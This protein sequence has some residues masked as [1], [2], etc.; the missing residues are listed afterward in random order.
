[1][2]DPLSFAQ[3]RLWF[4][5]QLDGPNSG[6]NNP[7]V[8]KL[9]GPLDQAA[10]GAALRDVLSRHESLRTMF[11][12]V[13]GEPYQRVLAVDELTWDLRVSVPADVAA[14]VREAVA[15]TFDLAAEIPIRAWLFEVGPEDHVLVLVVH[16]I[17]SDGWSMAP[18]G[19][20][21]A[22]AYAA[23]RAGQEPDW[24]ELPVQYRDYARWQHKLLGDDSDPD[25][26]LS[27]QVGYWRHAL[28]GA[29]EELTLPADRPRP[30]T[31]SYEGVRA[32]LDVPAHV[33][34]LVRDVARAARATPFMVLQAAFAVLLRRLG[35]GTDIPIGASV[36]GRTDDDLR[37]LVGFFVNTLVIR[38]DLAGD[39][40][41]RD[42][43]ARVRATALAAL[44]N[45]DVPFEKL[46]GDLAP[47]RS[48]SRH[49]LFQVMLTV[50][51][52]ARGTLELPDVQVDAMTAGLAAAKFDLDVNLGEVFDE[53]GAPAG[54][55]GVLIAAADLFDQETV[56]RIARQF[57]RVLETAV[58]D[59]TMR[60]DDVDVLDDDERRRILIEWNDA[61]HAVR[62]RSV[63]ESVAAVG[64]D[65]RLYVLDE[66]LRPVPP[67][68]VGELYLA[69]A[70]LGPGLPAERFVAC[71]F[72]GRMYRSG[73][74]ARWT[75]DGSV[76]LADD[77]VE[78]RGE[79]DHPVSATSTRGRT[80]VREELLRGVFAE[81]LG[82]ET[83]GVDDSFFDLG[84]YSLSAVR[85][86]SRI[87][88]VLGLEVRLRTLFDAPSVAQ[89][90]TRLEDEDQA[91]AALVPWQRP[92]RIPLSFA[93]RRLWFLAQI[94]G[95]NSTYNVP[96]VLRL[97]GELDRAALAQAL[98]DVLIRHESLR[99]I[100]AAAD[101]EPCQRIVDIDDLDW[102]PAVVDSPPDL[103]AAAA[104]CANHAF[105]LAAELP[106][107][108]WLFVVGPAEHVLV[109]VV[110]HIAT[111]G[112]S[113][114][115]LT[116]DIATAYTARAGGAEP[117]WRPLPVQYADYALWQRNLLGDESDPDSL[118]AKQVAYW[119]E[120]LSGTPAELT[121]PTDH[122]RP[123]T[124][125]HR[126]IAVPLE[127]APDLHR[128]LLAVA[129]ARGVTVFMLL[130]ASLAILLSRLGAG[131]DIPIG[132]GVAGRTDEALDD[133]VG[134][135]VNTLVVRTD[136]TGDPT[137]VDVLARVRETSLAGL[138]NQ[139][140]PFE[141][142]VEELAPT[143]SL[144]RNPLFQ[145][146]LTV[147]N[148]TR[149]TVLPELPGVRAETMPAGLTPAK[150]D[151]E[152]SLG[153]VLGDDGAP[154]GLRGALVG[155][156]DLF[157]PASVDR[158]AE[159]FVRLVDALTA[160]PETRLSEVDVLATAERDRVVQ[161]WNDT[162]AEVPA[163]TLPEMFA[164]QV[165]R[166]PDAVAVAFEDVEL[167]YRQLRGRVD[168][169]ARRLTALGVGPESVVAVVLPRSA[170]LVVT[171]LAI[172]TAGGAYLPIDPGYPV[173]RVALMAVDAEALCVVT[174]GETGLGI[175]HVRPDEPGDGP[176]PV[177]PRPDNPA[178]VIY[179]S[180]STG[181]PKGVVSTHRG[182]VNRLVWMRRRYGLGS[183]DRVL[184]KT[185]YGF[186][187]SVWE[188]FAPLLFGATLV[189]ARPEGHKDPG[190]LATL[191]RDRRITTAHFVPS[192]LEAF[193]REPTAGDCVDLRRV[194]CSGEALPLPAQQRFF[195]VFGDV[196]LH[197]L[198]GPT[199]ASVEV[200]AWQCEPS[201]RCGS[202]PIGAPIANTRMYVLDA[203]LQPVAPGVVG[204]LYIAGVQLARGYISRPGLTAER[205]VACP[206]GGRMYRTGDRGKWTDE[207]QL[208]FAGR[209]DDQVKIRGFRIEPGEVQAVV[210]AHPGVAQ[211][212]VVV[213]DERL[214]AYVVAGGLDAEELRRHV[215]E[216]LPEHMVP[217]AIVFLDELP[218]TTNGKLD[219]RALPMPDYAA[220]AGG[221]GPGTVT[222][223]IL[224]G[225]FAEILG[226]DGVGVDDDFFALGGH[227]LLA[228]RLTSRVRAVLGVELPLRT[229]FEAPTVAALALRLTEAAPG[230][231]PLSP[232]ERPELVPLSFA[233][234][235]LWFI[236]QLD[237]PSPTYNVPIVLRL[238][239][240]VDADAL[241]DALRDVLCRH[242]ALRTVFPVV[243]GEPH[244]RI[245]EDFTWRLTTATIAPEAIDSV[246]ADVAGAAFDLA[247]DLPLRA[248][249]FTTG[250]DQHVFVLVAHHIA[251]DGWSLGQ[252]TRDISVAYEAR[253]AG[254]PPLWSALPVQYADYALW[255]R[256]LLGD[257]SDPDSLLSRQVGHWRQALTGAPEEL[258][259]PIDRPRPP[260]AGHRGVRVG[261]EI[262][263]ELHQRLAEVARAEG[264]TLFMVLQTAL[265]VLLNKFGAGDDIPVGAA[266]AGRTD[267]ALDDLVGFFVNTLVLRT[268]LSG[269]P[270][271]REVLARV[272]ETSLA[273]FGNQD[274]PFERLVEELAPARSLSRHP[275]F[276]VM[277]TL[278]NNGGRAVALD[279]LRVEGMRGGVPAAKFDLDFNVAE[280]LDADGA[281][282]GVRGTLTAAADLFDQATVERMVSR[283]L[284][285]LTALAEDPLT[286]LSQVD[287]LSAEERQDVLVGW[288]DT[289]AGLAPSVPELFAATV[290]TMPDAIA[291]VHGDV[292]LTYR[293]LAA[294]S[295]ALAGRLDIEPDDIVA[296][297]LGRGVDMII[298]ILA[299]W[300]AG[301][302]YLPIDPELPTDR[303]DFMLADSGARLVVRSIEGDPAPASP[304]VPERGQLAY[305]IYTSGS[306]GRPK[307]V[308]VTHGSLA[309][310]VAS[311]SERL[312]LGRAGD[313]YALLQA[314]VTDLGNTMVF[315]SLTTGGQ[316]HILD[317]DVVTD[318]RALAEYLAAERIDHLKAV[319]SHLMAL[320]A[321]DMA[322]MLPAGSLVLG[323]EAAPVDWVRELVTVA[324]DRPVFNHYG[325]T[326]TTIGVA[327][328][329][330]DGDGI[331]PIGTPIANT[332][333]Y[334][335]D[336]RLGLVPPGVTG[337]LYVAG[338]GLARGYVGRRGL[339]AERF[340]ANPF[341]VGERMYRTGD[342]VRWTSSQAGLRRPR[343]RPGSQRPS[344]SNPARSGPC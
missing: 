215:A 95:A 84:G 201:Q 37:D 267:V 141:R 45:Q 16:H 108:A 332:R 243:D 199:E 237:G 309:N 264:A 272:R 70:V 210:G 219:R 77:R 87:R 178:Y 64:P 85:L 134:F 93:Q 260:V 103:T 154:A 329:R 149:A 78:I 18:L 110:H 97:T 220:L 5:H 1:M 79:L 297:C 140:V 198:Y 278:Q 104:D 226:L 305:V 127:L 133:V 323:G 86:A 307:G 126:G 185:P 72:G 26:L 59:P 234:R 46:V 10:V 139:D 314:Q 218:V 175:P 80:S 119:R 343:R 186:D 143:R 195:E 290:A 169:M 101:G 28:A 206:F 269:D 137:F 224:C 302:A 194:I 55:R 25:S 3:R 4:I 294:R 317:A 161:G 331:V 123:T 225:A 121:L 118:M 107:R 82:L 265:S 125:T 179:T 236:G 132:S 287:V 191:I 89:L 57:V 336:T 163:S 341:E 337:E 313:R 241:G 52:T 207:G 205:F 32:A 23:R 277:L 7:I 217:A 159:R 81:I 144:A 29:P 24:G 299:V 158:V 138:A 170:E 155:A 253:R 69:A 242:E 66:R 293:E 289:A 283:L 15:C 193:L 171:L 17:A 338:A 145:V 30:H 124:A 203:N 142:L 51:N 43:V 344:A 50:Q 296:L 14:A 322:G 92:E 20:D 255:Q 316:L 248:W 130:Q 53:T 286:R 47:S 40:E 303:I 214:V 67:G 49:P 165:A 21:L 112:W 339:T 310:Y 240:A 239:G 27:R 54:L 115:P 2:T 131:L 340:V 308:A 33:H 258:A 230:R 321:H 38:A 96:R 148:A 167:T 176:A 62:D 75:N 90:V 319:P 238:F 162:T 116:Q 117:Q 8:L 19:R 306:T 153:E 252:L 334:V 71:P 122:P 68:V 223:E 263:V 102:E 61:D 279:G 99:T 168:R 31:T 177:G 34:G 106:I 204:E 304:A 298:A 36:A 200:T 335:L 333:C 266:V 315:T 22:Q 74:R 6:Y 245:V 261:V 300:Q 100:F 48:L 98:R 73:T 83:V 209:A 157:E 188:F 231:V 249:L 256:E 246:V 284:V 160:A 129:R 56:D 182:I 288:N 172:V 232:R 324:G 181:R 320:T 216:R 174:D 114:A 152:I 184:Q 262:P 11:P 94:E 35:A 196:E 213:R 254:V 202:V 312:R 65:T 190:Y 208:I 166:T 164:A 229:L 251:S 212:A 291:L 63:P 136:L 147:Q 325:P 146:M 42:V 12:E 44:A 281:P 60:V 295:A 301:G 221:R 39:P 150:V 274:V 280:R 276:Q 327:T 58:A 257:E 282:A 105:E 270:T 13:D 120:A 211:A 244:Q 330:L 9:T 285:V 189:V 41:F 183:G 233:Q 88:A 187:V 292:R 268:D 227:S 235:R 113:M 151:L 109:L 111:D 271:F 76:L 197:N 311:V 259:L 156:A 318:P 326:E 91:R 192:M 128:R 180:G 222:E 173:D 247:V 328:T 250:P 273:A 275:L 342:R 228:V 135:F